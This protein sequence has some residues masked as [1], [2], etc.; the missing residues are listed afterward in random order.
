MCIWSVTILNS[1]PQFSVCLYDGIFWIFVGG[2][3][4]IISLDFYRI[5]LQL[6]VTPPRNVL[7]VFSV[8]PLNLMVFI[9]GSYQPL[10]KESQKKE[11]YQGKTRWIEMHFS[12]LLQIIYLILICRLIFSFLGGGCWCGPFPLTLSL[13]GCIGIFS[14]NSDTWMNWLDVNCKRWHFL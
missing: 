14:D 9:L 11:I 3:H 12:A 2:G 10:H 6:L 8:L 13:E 1:W 7:M 5:S 4:C